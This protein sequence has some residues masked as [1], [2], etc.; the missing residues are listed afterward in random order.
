MKISLPKTDHPSHACS[1]APHAASCR[2]PV[3]LCRA[4]PWP[5]LADSASLRAAEQ[6]LERQATQSGPRTLDLFL[7]LEAVQPGPAT[8]WLAAGPA[9]DV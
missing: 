1:L 4:A 6:L 5:S 7:S 8:L 2:I 9:Q 3:K